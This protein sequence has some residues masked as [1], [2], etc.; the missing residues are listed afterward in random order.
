MCIEYNTLVSPTFEVEILHN[1]EGC[2]PST[3]SRELI[4]EQDITDL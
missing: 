4:D 3:L 1:F 2:M